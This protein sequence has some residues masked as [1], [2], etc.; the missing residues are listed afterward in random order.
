MSAEADFLS[1]ELRSEVNGCYEIGFYRTQPRTFISDI[2]MYSP[3][4]FLV[5]L[6]FNLDADHV[7]SDLLGAA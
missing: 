6:I 5:F 1:T 2:V 3:S 7:L 4:S